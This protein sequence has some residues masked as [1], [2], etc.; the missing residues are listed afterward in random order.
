MTNQALGGIKVIECGELVCAPYCAKLLA[1]LGAEVIK[2]EEPGIGDVARRRG[3]FL[4]DKPDPECS[5]LFLYVNTSKL[6]I[7]LNLRKP[8]GRKLFKE[9]IS[10]AD[11]LVHD[12]QPRAVKQLGLSFDKLKAINPALVVTAVTAFGQTGPYKD[13]K[14]YPLNSFHSGGEGY[15]TPGGSTYPDR[16]PLNLGKYVVEYDTALVAAGATLV[17]YYWRQTS[18]VGQLVDISKQETIIFKAILDLTRYVSSGH[19][20][21]RLTR[22]YRSGG[23]LPC[24]DGWIEFTPQ[25]A[26]DWF[27]MFKLIGRS[28]LAD[29][30]TLRNRRV[31]EQRAAEIKD[32]MHPWLMAHTKEEI[33]HLCQSHNISIAPINSIDESVNSEQLKARQFFVEIEHP[34]AGKIKFPSAPY[35][36]TTTPWQVKCPAPLLGQHNEEIYCGRLGY[37]REDLVRLRETGII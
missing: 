6:G 4:N 8:A 23:P 10:G 16:P 19:L 36:F 18:G 20:V 37:S 2:I 28:D 25:I 32:I 35:K 24:K 34:K 29:D 12:K 22:G 31:R 11:I 7:T 33:Y 17:A 30:E 5:G 27:Q 14:A 21:T 9:L 26:E 15:L 1:D 3:P 13:Y